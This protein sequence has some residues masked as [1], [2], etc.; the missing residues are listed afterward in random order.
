MS[1]DNAAAWSLPGVVE[2]FNSRRGATADVYPSEW[3]FLRD[4]LKDGVS[5]LDIGCAQGGFAAV[6]GEHARRFTYTGIDISAEMIAAARTRHPQH[7]FLH[8]PEGD[9]SALGDERFDLVLVLGILHLHESWRETLRAGWRHTR[10]SLVFDLRQ[11]D[12]PT[13]E[14]KA[15]SYSR[16]DFG[17][18]DTTHSAAHIPYN[19]LNAGEALGISRRICDGAKRLSLHGYTMSVSGAAVTPHPEVLASVYCAER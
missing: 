6:A 19:V 3:V 11:T 10:G 16:M 18:Q 13:V 17:R 14:D 7:R 15:R 9:Y 1:G 8:V 4:R 5:V 12:G 2:Y